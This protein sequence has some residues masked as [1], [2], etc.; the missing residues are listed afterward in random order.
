MSS[1]ATLTIAATPEHGP[2]A[3]TLTLDC[4]HGTST[5]VIIPAET[6]G[7]FV[8]HEGA[9]VRLLILKHFSVE[10]CDCT[11]ALRR[12]YGLARVQR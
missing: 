2:T 9:T 7:A 4:P 10:G 5:G 12:R 8:P 11:A 3:K 1:D 6:P